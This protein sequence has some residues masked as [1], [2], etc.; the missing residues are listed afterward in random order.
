[1][2]SV[3]DLATQRDIHRSPKYLQSAGTDPGV[4]RQMMILSRVGWGFGVEGVLVG[5][6]GREGLVIAGR[7]IALEPY[8]GMALALVINQCWFGS[9]CF[10]Q[11]GRSNTDS[12]ITV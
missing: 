9:T 3:E 8:H 7:G 12:C 6:S 10:H 4:E 5:E 2:L 1:M 11:F